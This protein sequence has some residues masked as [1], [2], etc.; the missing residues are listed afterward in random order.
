[1]KKLFTVAVAIGTLSI[2]GCGDK[3]TGGDEAS[4][5]GSG[6]GG[7]DLCSAYTAAI[8][9]CYSEA[10]VDA[11]ALGITETYCDAY[12]GNTAFDSYF[13][14]YIDAIAAADCSTVD[15]INELGTAAATCA[16]N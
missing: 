2:V 12:V 16:P 3:D 11:A 7:S 5:G 9:E 4:D 10:G 15:G 13:S 1:M 6:S 8:L 14:C